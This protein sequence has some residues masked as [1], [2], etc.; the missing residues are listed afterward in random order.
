[1]GNLLLILTSATNGP[2]DSES[3]LNKLIPNFWAFLINFIAFIVMCLIVLFFAYKP[4]KKILKDRHQYVESNIKNSEDKLKMS[5]LKVEEANN[6]VKESKKEAEEIINKAK[7]T[8]NRVGDEIINKA[9]EDAKKEV[10]KAQEE[11]KYE[12]E[13]S[14]DEIHKEIV[15]VSLLATEKILEREIDKKDNEKFVD[16]FINE[17][18]KD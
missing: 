11:I 6:T 2:I 10:Q 4:I 12:I 17:L 13:K 9:K 14:K 7:E 8:A 1:M 3:I 5:T 18:K 16:D 15:D